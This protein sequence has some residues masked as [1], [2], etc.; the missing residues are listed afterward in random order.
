MCPR[1]LTLGNGTKVIFGNGP[2]WN[3]RKVGNQSCLDFHT[4]GF[5]TRH[6]LATGGK[7]ENP[8]P[9]LVANTV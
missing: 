4:R 1:L 6:G 3:T 8:D 9:V 7:V 5:P 2:N